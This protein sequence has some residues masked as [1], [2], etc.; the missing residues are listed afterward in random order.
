MGLE[1]NI[2]ILLAPSVLVVGGNIK[3]GGN[4]NLG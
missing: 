3:V 2:I 4:I 1:S